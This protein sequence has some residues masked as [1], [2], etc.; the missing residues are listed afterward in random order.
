MTCPWRPVYLASLTEFSLGIG[1]GQ[2]SILLPRQ[3]FEY[4]LSGYDSRI[5]TGSEIIEDSGKD[6]TK[7]EDNGQDRRH[8]IPYFRKDK[9]RQKN[10][11]NECT[12]IPRQVGPAISSR[13]SDT[14]PTAESVAPRPHL[15]KIRHCY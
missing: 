6:N 7:K 5:S 2:R 1:L 9:D 14:P 8:I 12:D 15:V 11:D 4:R 3:I 10:H 13:T